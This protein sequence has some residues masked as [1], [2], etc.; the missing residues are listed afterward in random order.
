ML[1]LAKEKPKPAT[2]VRM[3]TNK[4]FTQTKKECKA[5]KFVITNDG[6]ITTIKDG[7]NIVL[8]AFKKNAQIVIVTITKKYFEPDTED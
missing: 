1:E 7:E 6:F 5:N 3:W 8:T 2:A 4:E